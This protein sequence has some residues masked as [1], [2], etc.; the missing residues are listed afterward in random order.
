MV[1]DEDGELVHTADN[2]LLVDAYGK[3]TYTIDDLVAVHGPRIPTAADA[4]WDFRAAAIIVGDDD[5]PVTDQHLQTVSDF[6][7]NYSR[8]AIIDADAAANGSVVGFYQMTGG[9]GS[10][11]FDGLSQFLNP[12]AAEPSSL[13]SSFGTPPPVQ[14]CPIPEH[15]HRFLDPGHY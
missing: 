11:T 8:Q 5:T 14:Y 6:L 10:I 4:Q 15:R 2:S 1:R 3:R 7:T 13:P 12:T 9:R